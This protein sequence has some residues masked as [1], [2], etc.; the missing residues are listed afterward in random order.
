MPKKYR[1]SHADFARIPR[2]KARRIH[3]TYFSLTVAPLPEGSGPKTACVVSKKIAARAIDRNG[4]QRRCREVLRSH[5][6]NIK[7]P[8]A[9]V[10]HAKREAVSASLADTKKDIDLMVVRAGVLA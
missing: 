2:A 10:F 1:L 3:G 6:I 8:F 7:Q 5:L 4:I 9:L